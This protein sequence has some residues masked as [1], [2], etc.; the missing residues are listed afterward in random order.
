MAGRIKECDHR[1]SFCADLLTGSRARVCALQLGSEEK[2][3]LM[4]IR[5]ESLESFAGQLAGWID[6]QLQP[7]AYQWSA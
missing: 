3:A 2:Q 1:S 5:A 6:T 7:A 4:N